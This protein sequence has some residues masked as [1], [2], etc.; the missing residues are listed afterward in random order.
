M[1]SPAG[2]SGG[3]MEPF[4]L[5]G[6]AKVIRVKGWLNAVI[7]PPLRIIWLKTR[8]WSFNFRV[9]SVADKLKCMNL[10]A[11]TIRGDCTVLGNDDS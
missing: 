3:E 4:P 10:F 8:E 6:F 5:R 2:G 9:R 11:V 1:L 7:A